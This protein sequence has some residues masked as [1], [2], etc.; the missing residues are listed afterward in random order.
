MNVFIA[1]DESIVLEGLKHIIPWQELGFSLCGEAR[2]GEEA[3]QKILHLQPD[4][5]LID[6]R[7]PKMTGLE[8]VQAARSKQFD[9][10]FMILSGISDFKYAQTAMRNGVDFYLTKPI[11]EDDLTEAVLAVRDALLREQKDSHTLR[12]YRQKAKD[13]ILQDLLLGNGDT[14]S[15]DTQDLKLAAN[16]YQVIVYEN[17]NQDTFY[18]VWDFADILRVANQDNNSF[19]SV[20]VGNNNVILLKGSFAIE[21]FQAL[22][23]HYDANPQKGSPLDSLFLSFG[24]PVSRLDDIHRSYKDVCVLM[25]RRFFCEPNQHVMGY[26]QLPS[27]GGYCY[28]LNTQESARYCTAF[29]DCIQAHSRHRMVQTLRELQTNL[30]AASDSVASVKLFL[31]DIYLQVKQMIAGTYSTIDIPFP[32]NATVIDLI[33]G[34]YYLYEIIRFLSEQ[35]EIWIKATTS[36][37]S[38]SVLDDIL[39]YIDHNYQENL[40]LETIAPLFGYN[41]S[42]L[43][44]IFAKK[45]GSSFNSYVDHIR[46]SESQKLLKEGRLKVYEIAERVG[47]SNVDY[48][49]KKFKK[50]VGISP[51]E[52]RRQQGI[53]SME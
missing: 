21:R 11:D 50:Y 33:E 14:Y 13:T 46:I 51:A 26:R 12:Q 47:Y 31:T 10:K 34:K 5:V 3:L 40:K 15:L 2:D 30:Y 45:A 38:E 19:D 17:Y 39:Y 44:K 20:R 7:M 36:S 35:F 49:H 27:P 28:T 32:P 22:L 29:S 6:I 4:L 52:Y 41:S 9:G 8:V 37:D 18:N 53:P 25:K 23:A 42:Y 24:R 1:D 48:F 43:G 16:I